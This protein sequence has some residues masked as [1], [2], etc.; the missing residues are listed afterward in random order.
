MWSQNVA[1][2]WPAFAFLACTYRMGRGDGVVL[3]CAAAGGIGSAVE[4]SL[5][6]HGDEVVASGG[7]RKTLG[8]LAAL[9]SEPGSQGPD[10]LD[11]RQESIPGLQEARW[12]L[13][14][15]HPIWR[16][17]ENDVPRP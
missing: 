5:V 17:R 2:R 7:N 12:L 15:T 8:P 9:L 3:W 6:G 13:C 14:D 1:S 16:A 11:G 4:H 10:L